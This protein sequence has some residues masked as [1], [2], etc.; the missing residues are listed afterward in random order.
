S[1]FVSGLI[2]FAIALA[3][4]QV[5]A[6][7]CS[8]SE[9]D[10]SS[11][12]LRQAAS[13]IPL[14]DV[15]TCDLQGEYDSGNFPQFY[16][17]LDK[18][19]SSHSKSR[20][21]ILELALNLAKDSIEKNESN[22]AELI[23]Q[24]ILTH[25]PNESRAL[26]SYGVAHM[27]REQYD[28]ALQAFT[29]A[30]AISPQDTIILRNLYHLNVLKGNYKAADTFNRRL[31][32][33]EPNIAEYS[34]HQLLLDALLTKKRD[35]K[36]WSKFLRTQ[37]KENLEFWN[38]FDRALATS[39]KIRDYDELIMIGNQ[40]IDVGMASD[41]LLLFDFV[42]LKKQAPTAQFLKAKAFEQ[43]KYYKLAFHSA[44][45]ALTMVAPANSENRDLYGSILYEAVRLGYAAGEYERSLVLL[46]EFKSYGYSN[47]HL[48]YMFAVNL[49][50]TG[51]YSE[52]LPYLKKCSVQNLPDFMRSFCKEKVEIQAK[53]MTPEA[54]STARKSIQVNSKINPPSIVMRNLSANSSVSW[55]GK[56]IAANVLETASTLNI[57]LVAQYLQPTSD[58]DFED[59]KKYEI[60]IKPINPEDIFVVNL[61]FNA[62]TEEQISTLK[63]SITK[64]KYLVAQGR[65]AYVEMFKKHLIPGVAIEKAIF[66][67]SISPR[68]NK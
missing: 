3:P 49:D 67:S 19:L 40:W 41:A 60:S 7:T 13:L 66:T 15:S 56:V 58:A 55:L 51:K 57:R 17:D 6:S 52:A 21:S 53:A 10:S 24:I 47:P 5:T 22:R 26:S 63:N 4:A 54:K 27:F 59:G 1:N 61:N 39:I 45:R 64:E 18:G 50:A 29:K 30:I 20:A 36:G 38:Y 43:G 12:N 32:R 9:A 46:N 48:D 28:E 37:S 25:Y 68:E 11:P 35:D 31:L 65:I 62:I 34:I 44:L 33:I 23:Y 8:K 16:V 14:E 2:A 42:L